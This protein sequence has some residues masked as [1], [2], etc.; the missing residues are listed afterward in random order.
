MK[1]RLLA[2]ASAATLLLGA[3]GAGATT[4]TFDDLATGTTLSTQYAGVTFSPNAFSGAGAPSGNW[5]TNTD[6]TVVS[7]TGSDVGAIGTPSLVSGN[8]LR[9]FNAW[10]N[11]NGD[12]SF[13]VSFASEIDSF[14]TDFAGVDTP[15]DVRL[16]AYNGS[17]LLGTVVGSSTGQFTLSFAAPRITSLVVT[18][19]DF[20]DYVG[21]DNIRYQT[22]VTAV[23]EPGIFALVSLGI[24]ALCGARRR[25]K[26]RGKTA[27]LCGSTS[28]PQ[29][30]PPSQ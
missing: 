6:M 29:L 8:I 17:T 7:A 22:A 20:F 14:S 27:S 19:G 12:P 26:T 5:A 10:T 21:V 9:S 15:A 23:P 28:R 13:R 30:R 11:E 3:F 4:L 16:F 18:P 2:T 1:S 24:V 25:A